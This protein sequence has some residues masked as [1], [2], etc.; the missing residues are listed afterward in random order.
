MW[1]EEET[2][3]SFT[4]SDQDHADWVITNAEYATAGGGYYKLISSDASIVTPSIDWTEYSD[5]TITISARKFGGPNETQGKISVSQGEVELATYSPSG[6]SIVA[7]SALSISPTDGT[8]T[9]SC[10]GASSSKGCGVQSIVIKGN[11]SSGGQTQTVAAPTFSPAAG[12]FSEAQN[13]TITTT[14]DGA[15]IYYTIDGNDPTTSSD[16]YSSAITVSETTTIK[17]M[18]VKEGMNNSA[19]ATATYTI[20][21][22]YSGDGYVRIG[23]LDDLTDGAKVIIAARYNTT[24]NAYYAMTA[25]ATGKPTGVAFTSETTDKGEELPATILNNADTYYWTV[26]V[27]SDG[28]IFTN[29]SNKSLGYTSGT[30]FAEGGDNTTWV[31]TRE[32]SGDAAMV[33]GYEGFYFTNKT[34]TDRGIALNNQNNFGPYSTSNNNSS[35]Y[36]FYLDIF[37]E[38]ATPVSVPSISARNVELEY[39]ATEGSITYTINNGVE[40]GTVS[41]STEAE[42]LTLGQI[43]DTAP[44]VPFTCSANT[45]TTERTATVTLTYTYGDNETV[46]KDVTVT[47]AGALVIASYTT[48]P[49]LFAAATSTET[50]VNVTFDSWVVSG[51]STNGKNVFVTDN[52]GNG[53]V[54]YSSSDMSGTYSAGSVLSGTVSCKLKLYNGFAELLNVTATDL[55]ITT[56]GTVSV[57][58]IAMAN[59]AGVNTGALVSY[60]NLTCSVSSGKYYLS[61]G[62]TTLQVYNALYTFDALEDGKT[63]NITGIYQQYNNTKEILPRSAADIEEVAAPVVASI[64]VAPASVD[65]D[66]A[67]HEG[68]LDLTYENLTV[69]DMDDFVIQFYDV[70]GAPLD[71]DP[72]WIEVLVAEQDPQVGEGYVV[73]YVIEA[74][75]GDARTATFKVYALDND[76]EFVYSNLITITQAKYV[77]PDVE[78]YPAVA[79]VGAF[80]KVTST[81]DIT[82]GNYL[83]VYEGNDTH[84]A[85]AF[86]GGLTELDAANNGIKV[87]IVDD[88]IPATTATVAATFTIQPSGSLKSASG[89]YIGRATYSNGLD[90]E[91]SALTNTFAIDNGCAVITAEG[92]CTLRY[93]YASDNLRFRYYKSGQQAIQLYKYDATAPAFDVIT[94][95][96][97]C[98]DGE[99]VY[100]TFSSSSAFVVS[101]DIVVS[102][103]GITDG[104]LNVQE[105]ETGVIV[106]AN[107][108]VMVSALEAG[109]YAVTLSADAGTSVLGTDNCLRPS[110]DAGITANEM[111]A[112]DANSLF[113]RLTMHNGETLGFWWGAAEGAAF[114]LA[115]NK[116]YL[117]VPVNA[118]R[119]G[120]VLGGET[121]AI[122]GMKSEVNENAPVYNMQGQRVAQPAKGLYIV[123]GKKYINK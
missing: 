4:A 17:A 10:P 70:T 68:T 75:T 115:A 57:A 120:F 38:G 101:D 114:A 32:T 84:D 47:Q 9:I 39:D 28:Y 105:Y 113:Y 80:V 85:V 16:V 65:V 106:P 44:V 71:E 43:A 37:V 23:S 72:D 51:V 88:K 121:T 13:V 18:A 61:D 46:T 59:L 79:G 11:K 52:N 82:A 92:G 103:V 35:S 112:A 56:G 27:T 111:A 74:N 110:G 63:Y 117:T 19:V 22:P 97:A 26:E 24:A 33:S 8:I 104:K 67:E 89:L 50:A 76:A 58:N 40:G 5:I 15:T 102:E 90:V 95:N 91:E 73:S 25:A 96:A 30:N 77:T 94:L 118:A 42:W 87:A 14:T 41:A 20:N 64:T 107:T 78:V 62:T 55:T 12:T 7:S 108:G 83:I 119:P 21:L 45:E 1:A 66:A 69:T 48:I 98:T 109:N 2:I 54:I 29:S 34:K 31:I 36:N 99:M 6:T 116:A 123:N 100:G 3:A 81:E 86:N 93:N 49:E 60:E 122:S 53:F